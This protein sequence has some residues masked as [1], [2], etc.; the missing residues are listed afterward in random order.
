MYWCCRVSEC[1]CI[2]VSRSTQWR[3]KQSWDETRNLLKKIC[4]LIVW[5]GFLF[6]DIRFCSTVSF[7]VEF[8]CV[9]C[10][11]SIAYLPLCVISCN[12]VCIG[13]FEHVT[14]MHSFLLCLYLINKWKRCFILKLYTFFREVTLAKLSSQPYVCKHSSRSSEEGRTVIYQINNAGLHF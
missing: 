3:R 10:L 2:G 9:E 14:L 1:P 5:L 6:I 11:R 4:G 7:I 13:I 8:V 12:T